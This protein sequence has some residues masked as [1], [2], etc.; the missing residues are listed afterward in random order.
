MSSVTFLGTGPGNGSPGRFQSCVF[1][2][3]DGLRVLLDAGEPCGLKLLEIGVPLGGLDAV[4]ITHAHADHIGGLAMLLQASW[5]HGRQRSLPIGVPQH[6]SGPF[7]VWLDAI[8]LPPEVLGFPVEIFSWQARTAVVLDEVTV[9][10]HPTTHLDHTREKTGNATI[11][12]FL[13]EILATGKRFIYSG[14]LGAAQDLDAVLRT[15]ADL[16]ICELAHFS[17]EELVAALRGARIG[18]LCLTHISTDL[19]EHRGELQ[20]LF[21]RELSGTDTVYLPDDG[22]SIDL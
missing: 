18:T 13:F 5:L 17:P 16:L 10:P 1:L 11:E 22:E 12:S 4:W 14:D 21:E 6:L 2:N 8:L 3:V 20:V 7:R 19:D 9:V 15:P